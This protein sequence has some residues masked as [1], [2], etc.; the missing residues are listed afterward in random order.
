MSISLHTAKKYQIEYTSTIIHGSMSQDV[1]DMI[2]MEFEISTNKGDEYDSEYD[3]HRSE[4]IRL[5]DEIVNQTEYYKEREAFLREQLNS[6]GLTI[7]QFVAALNQLITTSDQTN[8]HVLLS[9]Y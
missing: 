6:I 1:L 8:D 7:E 3:L 9:W 2:F 4:L 5:R